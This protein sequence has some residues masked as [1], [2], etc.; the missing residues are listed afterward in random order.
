MPRASRTRPAAA[1]APAF[2][3]QSIGSFTRISKYST[4]VKSVE[5][6]TDRVTRKR[7]AS[8]SVEEPVDTA[9][10][11]EEPSKKATATP[12]KRA[13]RRA[14]SPKRSAVQRPAKTS[15]NGK[16]SAQ[17]TLSQAVTNREQ[18][19]SNPQER[20]ARP[21]PNVGRKRTNECD[22]SPPN[23]LPPHL[24]DLVRLNKALLKTVAVHLAHC[25]SHVPISIGAITPNLSRT[26]GKRQ[27]TVDDFR[28]CIAVQAYA[29]DEPACPLV[30]SDYGRG[31]I[32]VELAP[33][34]HDHL[35]NE[36]R[37]QAQ[38]ERNLRALCAEKSDDEMADVDVPFDG[39]TLADLPHAAIND[40]AVGVRLN[41][42]LSK[43]RRDLAHLKSGILVRQQESRAKQ[44]TPAPGPTPL[45]PDGTKM[46]LLDRL[47]LK[48][49]SRANQP[50]GPSGPEL[51]RRAALNRVPDVA[52]TVSML[53]LSNPLSLPRQAFTMSAIAERLRDS[54]RTPISKEEAVACV[55]LI[56]TEVAPEWLR[57]V[58][59]GGRDNM[60]VQRNGQ[61]VD[62]VIQERVQKLL[63]A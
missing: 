47:R 12:S 26:W 14:Q 16:R 9:V 20:A 13:C 58:T 10:G 33:D 52:A 21:E 60:V 25:G 38:F 22:A 4:I 53:S 7:K 3:H 29:K 41:P 15:V 2:G 19:A 6:D 24:E 31:Q 27:V 23:P 62:R 56:A 49:L 8:S 34:G 54:L 1:A 45:N 50:L 37:L 55:R 17:A 30:I 51:E 57:I 44:Q 35:I 63:V 18:S 43:G 5:P 32:C 48:Q 59:I 61:P 40:R 28:R 46:S 36:D 42:L 39:L 11:G